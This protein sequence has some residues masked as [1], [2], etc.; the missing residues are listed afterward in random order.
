[1]SL[2]ADIPCGKDIYFVRV[3]FKIGDERGGPLPGPAQ[4][5]DDLAAYKPFLYPTRQAA[6]ESYLVTKN[7]PAK[8]RDKIHEPIDR[9]DLYDG[10]LDSGKEYICAC[11]IDDNGDVD[12]GRRV[13]FIGPRY[14]V[15]IPLSFDEDFL[16]TWPRD[17]IFE[18][19][20][21]E[22]PKMPA[23]SM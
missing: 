4:E 2:T 6:L 9:M 3:S 20:N 7:K 23:P 14:N 11:T 10:P 17:Y 13:Y 21:I 5:V 22:D 15:V 16:I 12:L 8:I 19:W 1:V 18:I